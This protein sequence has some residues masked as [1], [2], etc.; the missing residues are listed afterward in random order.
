MGP[1]LRPRPPPPRPRPPP[2][3]QA[4]PPPA[5]PRGGDGP[6]AAP[7]RCRCRRRRPGA[8][9]ARARPP[10]GSAC[11]STPPAAASAAPGAAA[12]RLCPSGNGTVLDSGRPPPG[13][14]GFRLV[15]CPL[16]CRNGGLCLR[17]DACVCPPQ[18]TGKF[19]HLPGNGTR[20]GAGGGPQNPGAPELT[21]SVFT[22]PLANHRE[23]EDG[24]QSLVSVHVAH[25]P[26]ASIL[27]HQVE[28]VRGGDDEAEDP[29]APTP[30]APKGAPPAPRGYRV[31]AQSSPRV[32]PQDENSGYGYCFRHLRGG[33]CSSPL[34]GLRTRAVCCRGAGV[35]W[36]VRECHPCTGHPSLE[37]RET[38]CPQGF[39][40]L[41]GSCVDVDECQEGGLCQHGTCRNTRGSFACVCPPGFLLDSSRASCISHQVLSEA[42]GPCY[43]VLRE[44]RCSLPTLR[45][46]TRQ[47]CCCS[48]VGKAWGDACTRCPPFG[49]EGF[50]E[51][52]PAGPGYHY[53]AS[54]LRF[55]T[56]YLG[57]DPARVPLGRPP[58]GT[59]A[60]PATPPWQQPPGPPQVAPWPPLSPPRPPPAPE[61]IVVA[62]ATAQP[63][64]TPGDAGGGGAC[65]RDPEV[66]GPG[67]CVSRAG[68]GYLCLCQPG[69]WLGPHGTRCVDVD[70]CRRSPP[71]CA[72]GR[73]ENSLG[74][75]RCLCDPGY[76]PVGSQCQDVDECARS[77][78]PCSHGRCENLPGGYHCV[79]PAGYR[80]SE[81]D[82]PCEDI[83]ECDHHLACPGQECVNTPGSF[84]CQP[85]PDGFR[86]LGGRC[87]DVDECLVGSPCGP[88]GRC[89]NT[90]GSFQCQCRPGYRAGDAGAACED[91][92]ECLEGDFCF[93][94]GECLNTDGS[95][96]CLCAPGYRPGPRGS[97][98][99][100][101]DECE[102][103]G[104]CWGGRCLNT[105]GSFEC[106]CP[107]GFRTEADQAR[108]R[109]VDECQEYG[110]RL[111]GSQRCENVPGS[112]RC[113]SECPPGFHH[114]DSGECEDVDECSNGTLC[115]AH[116]T[117]HNLPGS[118]QCACDPGYET[119]PE[120]NHCVD[121]DECRTL[122]GVCGSERC[123]NADGSFLCLCPDSRH[124]FDPVAG[125]CAPP[126]T[127]NPDF[128]G[129]QIPF[130][131]PQ[132]PFGEPQIPFEEPRNTFEEPQNPFEEPQNAF[133]GPRNAFEEPQNAFE[134]PQN[135][136]EEPRNAFE[137]PQN[138]FEPRNTFE[139]PR[140]AFEGPQNAFE[141]P[142]NA[143]EGP[144]N[145]FEGPQNAFEGPQKPS[146]GLSAC[147][148]RACEELAPNVTRAQ[149]CCSLGW[150][151]GARCP[152]GRCPT[153][154]T[155][156]YLALCPHG[157]G[158]APQN[159]QGVPEDVDECSV[160][161]PGLCRGGL[162]RNAASS[163]TCF[164][165]AGFFF[166]PESLRCEDHDECGAQDPDPCQGGR[167]T[168]T[169]G[170]YLCSCPPGLVLDASQRRCVANDTHLEDAQAVCW[171]E[172][173]VDLVCGKPRLD[174]QLTYTECCCLAGQAWGMD[175]A[176]CPAPNSD[177]FEFLC[178]ALRPPSFGAPPYDYA[179]PFT[180]PLAPPFPP[181]PFSPPLNP[182][183]FGAGGRVPPL[184]SFR[185]DY[186]PYPFGGAG[187]GGG[188]PPLYPLPPYYGGGLDFGDPPPLRTRGPRFEP[189]HPAPPWTFQ[190]HGM[191]EEEEE[192]DD[193]DDEG[194]QE[195][196]GVLS[197]CRNGRCVRL[198]DGFTCACDPGFRLDPAHMDCRDVDECSLDPPCPP[199][200]CLNTPG[201]FRCLSPPPRPHF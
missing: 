51:I 90:Q 16:L 191:R 94:H 71:P 196:C 185:S 138:A 195:E 55:N 184:P 36:G 5:E 154:G 194:G 170:S 115:G 62:R 88:H 176:L 47:I 50:K 15:V 143:F 139:G 86:L 67:R 153:A 53:S 4:P 66:C 137:E 149:C 96:S 77:P 104:V 155:D 117:C 188:T 80:S 128:E 156:E 3:A 81:P 91:V 18:F 105:D 63:P 97:R 178:N 19:C 73:C 38:S 46:I 111:C 199:G 192:E 60:P 29:P 85:C 162:C 78:Q 144:Q 48:R 187:G 21:Q 22:L 52:C 197:G 181:P 119:A 180:P 132:I 169:L 125:R 24:V 9:R 177:D 127:P 23:E 95:F 40:H 35:A 7:G 87:A 84:R 158:R 134:G 17:R 70:E 37:Q 148:S 201:S 39:Q 186:D 83:D 108:C 42:R 182:D 121:V 159:P 133:E 123:E 174:R 142:R 106:R 146:W 76:Q 27:I 103:G 189:P 43:R 79:C 82:G 101:V 151:W 75:F 173:G 28:R 161:S 65:E 120:G 175:C 25:P 150:A 135:A 45:N 20:G 32:P 41:N 69:F 68:G 58:S 171:Q 54:D 166:D 72:H 33:E 10:P 93:P 165:P 124:E 109:D 13:G 99:L 126:F 112:Y 56:R 163:F 114:G 8:P 183:I 118:F 179:P 2:A 157:P 59:S 92:N 1:C 200:R 26:E 152:H 167:C 100:D 64:P 164:C 140:N 122:A 141:E 98:C 190:P 116:A 49:S 6:R 34:P 102:A 44:G 57:Q 130:Q 172:V 147:F 110:A 30:P 11:S 145:A 31:L 129:P 74:S 14:A 107:A 198:G 193:D 131:G 89:L 136:F 168:N 160:F 61:V 12:L 113:V